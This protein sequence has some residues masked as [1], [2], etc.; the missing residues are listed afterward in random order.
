MKL[1]YRPESQNQ[2]VD[3]LL[4]QNWRD[5][6]KDE[7]EQKSE[8]QKERTNEERRERQMTDINEGVD[9]AKAG[10]ISEPYL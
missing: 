8:E 4:R 2:N 10:K 3:G 6:E 1:T 7:P 5:K 9:L